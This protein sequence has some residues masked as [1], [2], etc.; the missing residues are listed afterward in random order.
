MGFASRRVRLLSGALSRSEGKPLSLS[1]PREDA[2]QEM[3]GLRLKA[4]DPAKKA[5]GV[6][7]ASRPFAGGALL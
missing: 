6:Q 5:D 7:R 1:S 3:V 4:I 2:R